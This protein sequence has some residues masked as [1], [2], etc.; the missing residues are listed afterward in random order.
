MGRIWKQTRKILHFIGAHR[1]NPR[2]KRCKRLNSSRFTFYFF[3]QI[4]IIAAQLRNTI[5]LMPATDAKE[6]SK[7]SF[8]HPVFYRRGGWWRRAQ[9]TP[10]YTKLGSHTSVKVLLELVKER[11]NKYLNCIHY[12]SRLM[13]KATKPASQ[14]VKTNINIFLKPKCDSTRVKN[15]FVYLKFQRR[16]RV[17]S[18]TWSI[19]PETGSSP[20]WCALRPGPTTP[21][22]PMLAVHE[23]SRCHYGPESNRPSHHKKHDRSSG[24]Q[25]PP[26]CIHENGG[27]CSLLMGEIS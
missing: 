27:K 19:P 9:R 25:T 17:L 1:N 6:S 4:F 18:L 10:M 3:F 15:Y 12:R 24:A 7:H 21:L 26:V 11:G 16:P 5:S 20:P 22:R 8:S 2:T 23:G 14:Q 13:I